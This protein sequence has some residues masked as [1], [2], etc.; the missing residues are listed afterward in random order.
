MTLS[1][2]GAIEIPIVT[3]PILVKN[4]RKL[5][6]GFPDTWICIPSMMLS[7]ALLD[8]DSGTGCREVGLRD[9]EE[10][11]VVEGQFAGLHVHQGH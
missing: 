10:G 5:S 2:D 6:T 3:M 7:A 9:F 8:C 4:S 11:Q 1:R